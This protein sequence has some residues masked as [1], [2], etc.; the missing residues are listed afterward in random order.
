M[1]WIFLFSDGGKCEISEEDETIRNEIST[2]RLSET[3]QR[4]G[5]FIV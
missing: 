4:K 1:N 3:L 5:E 2:T